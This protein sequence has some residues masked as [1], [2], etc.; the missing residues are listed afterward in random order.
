MQTIEI[1][2]KEVSEKFEKAF[3][4]IDIDA[5]CQLYHPQAIIMPDDGPVITGLDNIRKLYE[6]I[7]LPGLKE[8][9]YTRHHIESRQDLGIEIASFKT[10]SKDTAGNCQTQFGKHILVFKHDGSDWKVFADIWNKS[11]TV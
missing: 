8:Y 4:N 2:A 6:N 9:S 3:R 1:A 7:T 5:I 11:P 10:T